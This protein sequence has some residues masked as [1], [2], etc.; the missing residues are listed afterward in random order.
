VEII[1]SRPLLLAALKPLPLR[2]LE[3]GGNSVDVHGVQRYTIVLIKFCPLPYRGSGVVV[4]FKIIIKNKEIKNTN[5]CAEYSPT[6]V[7]ALEK[8]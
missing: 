4:G 5:Q 3:V 8:K 6:A 2:G 1:I 7:K